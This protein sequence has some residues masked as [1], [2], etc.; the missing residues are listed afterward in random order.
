E[1]SEKRLAEAQ[2][3]AHLGNWEWDIATDKVY[4]SDEAYRIFG[5]KPQEFEMTLSKFFNCVHP[6]DREYVNKAIKRALNGEPY[7][8]DFRI[9][10]AE[11]QE[12]II[13]AQGEAV[14][15]RKNIP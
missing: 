1:E 6:D 12:R 3:M 11:R 2:R 9:V 7:N 15:D 10:L 5:L 14:F 8:I 4:W 13:H